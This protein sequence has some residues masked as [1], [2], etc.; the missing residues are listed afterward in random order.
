MEAQQ[1]RVRAAANDA[2]IR[3]NLTGKSAMQGYSCCPSWQK[4]YEGGGLDWRFYW[5]YYGPHVTA[6]NKE[7][8]S[9]SCGRFSRKREEKLI[10]GGEITEDYA[11]YE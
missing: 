5:S 2:S 7:K 1:D 3:H 4:S 10:W 11:K 9:F 6:S 8:T